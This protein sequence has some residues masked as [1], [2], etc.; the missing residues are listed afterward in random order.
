VFKLPL[1][2]LSEEAHTVGTKCVN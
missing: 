1:D 2:V